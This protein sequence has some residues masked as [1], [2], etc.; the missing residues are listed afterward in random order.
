MIAP[1]HRLLLMT[2]G[3][4]V[5]AATLATAIPPMAPLCILLMGVFILLV[6]LDALLSGRILTHVKI[7]L[8]E[9]VRLSDGRPTP[10]KATIESVNGR[11]S[12]ALQ[13]ALAATPDVHVQEPICHLK[14][15]N[16]DLPQQCRWTLCGLRPGNRMLSRAFM[17][18]P[19]PL[20]LWLRRKSIDTHCEIR[21]YPNLKDDQ[22]RLHAQRLPTAAGFR[23]HPQIGKG[24][25]FDHLREYLSGDSYE[26]IHWKATARYGHPVTKVF[27]IERVQQIYVVMDMARLSG[28]AATHQPIA[29]E[30]LDPAKERTLLD[31]Y[32]VC[33]L[34]MALATERQGDQFGLLTFADQ[35]RHFVRAGSGKAHYNHCRD[36]L[37]NLRPQPTSPDFH[38]LF[39][40]IGNHLNRRSL[41]VFLTHLDDPVLAE[42][43]LGHIHI[44]SRKHLVMVNSVQPPNTAPLFS[45]PADSVEQIYRHL[46]GHLLF[47]DMKT[48]ERRLQQQ[49]IGFFLS[50]S[51]LL[52]AQVVSQY[53]DV[54]QRQAL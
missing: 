53:M 26:D 2:A 51:E 14:L 17:G 33:A 15:A 46:G 28:R 54:K 3:V 50:D 35:V 32:V 39:T 22:R 27:Q 5:P 29:K 41:L 49:G 37:Y 48:T 40:F 25:E 4:L 10:L 43:F 13:V 8:P 21:I 47:A 34:L 16:T 45:Q 42:Q 12:S 19:S 6:L 1:T 52:C 11:R 30:D 18:A 23:H 9:V 36:T 38:E 44:L 7:R 20:G 31:R 24:R